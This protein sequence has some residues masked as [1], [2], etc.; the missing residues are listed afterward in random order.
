VKLL[1]LRLLAYGPFTNVELDLLPAGVHVLYGR[2]EAGK[3]TALRAITG[4]L[5]GIPKNTPDAHLHRMPDL[6]V[7]GTI[8]GPNG[9][10]FRLVRRKGKENTLLDGD[11]HPV[12]EAVLGK[13][14]GGVSQ[15]QFLTMFGLDHDTLRRGGEALL[16]GHGNVG[17]SLFG[18]AMAGGELHQVLRA[19]RAE[20]DALFSPKAHTKPLNEAL[21]AYA[22]A[23]RRVRDESMSPDSVLA[24]TRGLEELRRERAECDAERLRLGVARA[25][26]ERARRALPVLAKRQLVADRRAALG[27]V[28]LLAADASARR[29]EKQ[30]DAREATLEIARLEAEI[31]EL[32]RRRSQLLVPESLVR[33]G[34]VPLD[35]ANRLGSHLKAARDLPRLAGEIDE[36]EAQ[37]RTILRGLGRDVPL[38]EA[39]MWRVDAGTQAAIRKL[40][41]D[42]VKLL[43]AKQQTERVFAERAVLHRGSSAKLQALPPAADATALEKAVSRAEREGPVDERLAKASAQ[44][45]RMEQAARAQLSA[46]GLGHLTLE[47]ACGLAVPSP[48]TIERFVKQWDALERD[49]QQMATERLD[50]HDHDAH[51]KRDIEALELGGKV[52]T[53]RDLEGARARR[54]ASLDL[55][56]AALRPAPSAKSRGGK[57]EELLARVEK[58]MSDADG[59]ADRLRR[60]AERVSRLAALLAERDACAH[61]KNAAAERESELAARRHE[62]QKEWVELWSKV[63]VSAQP[64]SEMR[65][66]MVRHAALVRAADDLRAIEAD[67]ASLGSCIDAHRRSL[68]ALL[69]SFGSP[70]PNSP[71]LGSLLDHASQVIERVKAAALERGQLERD[72]AQIESQLEG[73]SSQRQEH[74][75]AQAELQRAWQAAVARVG[76]TEKASP[77]QATATIDSLGEAFRKI[78]QAE[79]ERRRVSGIERDAQAFAHD[80]E[81]LAKEHAPDLLECSTERAA[82]EIIE[83]YHRGQTAL[84]ERRELDRQLAEA[85]RRL[86]DQRERLRAAEAHLAELRARADVDSLEALENAEARSDRAREL[87]R[88]CAEL[89]AELE[90]LGGDAASLRAEIEEPDLDAAEARTAE[91]ESESD[92]LRERASVIDGRIGSAEAGLR[93][94]GDP[95]ARAADAAAE[96]EAHLARVR[97]VADRYLKVRVAS[98]VLAREIER[99]R[100]ENQG[101]ILLRASELFRRL[102]LGSFASLTADFDEK[103]QPVLRGVRAAGPRSEVAVD[104]MSDGTRDQLYLALRLATLERYAEHHDPMPLVLDDILIHFD[105][106]RARAAL[107]VLGDIGG[108]TQVLFFTHHTRLVDLARQAIPP[109]K[110]LIRELSEGASVWREQPRELR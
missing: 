38:D 68:L 96:A 35:L 107:E 18:A 56:R 36:L 41:L 110:L 91:L 15:E 88:V 77:E 81:N 89:D 98:F 49:H 90:T 72:V 23:H 4:L 64:P 22:E 19:L 30:R 97:E 17:E 11:G 8:R 39:G 29:L 84:A 78:D 33:Y 109:Q 34:E 7:G 67:A 44:A 86:A 102:T 76:L 92:Q 74:E 13:M 54:D 37:A 80:V 28:V 10:P 87:D 46:L 59:I 100:Q 99:Y 14:L 9:A 82:T 58:D 95:K 103:D 101:P 79:A 65:A 106:E 94:L 61:R 93:D 69:E 53:E 16:L 21:K 1:E 42:G 52:P 27:D 32:R 85:E 73:L 45:V 20:A 71:S 105:D 63:A 70:P 104:A 2:N 25:K 43:E 12:D 5:Y 50:L 66:W 48:E 40:A 24:Q 31:S 62:V 26:L 6:R 55:L 75:R 57:V 60:E 3:S 51:L 83:R 108:R 47:A